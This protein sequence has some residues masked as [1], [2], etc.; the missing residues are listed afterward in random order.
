MNVI[1]DVRAMNVNM[2]VSDKSAEGLLYVLSAKGAQFNASLG[3][4]GPRNR[5]GP[6]ITK[7]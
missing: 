1:V 5:Y 7:R 6:K 4:D 3:A 2:H